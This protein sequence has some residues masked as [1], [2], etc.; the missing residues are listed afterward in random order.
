MIFKI[1][2]DNTSHTL[3]SF[4]MSAPL[5]LIGEAPRSLIDVA[6]RSLIGEGG[7]F[8]DR[9]EAEAIDSHAK[10]TCV[11]LAKSLHEKACGHHRSAGHGGWTGLGNAF[12]SLAFGAAYRIVKAISPTAPTTESG[13]SW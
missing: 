2:R 10:K 7:I 13:N 5:S 9:N 3:H 1:N 6:P 8:P 4:T 12:G 11:Q